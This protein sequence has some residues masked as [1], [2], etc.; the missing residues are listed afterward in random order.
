[1]LVSQ[2]P[3]SSMSMMFIHVYHCLSLIIPVYHCSFMFIIVL[4]CLMENQMSLSDNTGTLVNHDCHTLD[5]HY[6]GTPN[7]HTYQLIISSW[8][9]TMTTYP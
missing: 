1:M 8:S 7:F 3:C 2:P 6:G 5:C 4:P 9:V